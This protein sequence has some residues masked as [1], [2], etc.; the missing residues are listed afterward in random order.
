MLAWSNQCSAFGL[1]FFSK[2]NAQTIARLAW[3]ALNH[4]SLFTFSIYDDIVPR[5]LILSEQLHVMRAIDCLYRTWW[6]S[7]RCLIF[8]K[9]RVRGAY[10]ATVCKAG[11]TMLMINI[12]PVK[13]TFAPRCLWFIIWCSPSGKIFPPT[14]LKVEPGGRHSH[15]GPVRMWPFWVPPFWL[16]RLEN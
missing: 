5:H 1:V 2:L 14:S 7:D 3:Q 11:G 16:F 9:S 10:I 6:S 4:L 12:K 8:Q 13:R 15:T